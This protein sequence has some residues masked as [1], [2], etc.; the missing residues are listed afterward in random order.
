MDPLSIT[1]ATIAIVQTISSTYDTIQR[2][3]GLP[4]AFKEVGQELHLVKETLD[5]VRSQLQASSLDDSTQKAIEPIIRGCQEKAIALNGI[6]QEI[7]KKKKTDK[8]AKD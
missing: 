3:K 1:V 2:L 4:K 5:L 6:F 7:E 8:K